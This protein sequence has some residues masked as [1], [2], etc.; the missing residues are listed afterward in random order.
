MVPLLLINAPYPRKLK[1]YGQPTSL[2]YASAKVAEWLD[3]SAGPDAARLIN[4]N[5]VSPSEFE[6]HVKHALPLIL[7]E[8]RPRVVAI[9]LTT[10][11]LPAARRL[12]SVVKENCNA[13]VVFGGP[14]EDDANDPT[15]TWDS[16][17]DLSVAGDGECALNLIVQAALTDLRADAASLVRLLPIKSVEGTA[18]IYYRVQQG[19][20]SPGS[21]GML[22][23][24][25][26][27]RPSVDISNLPLQP[28]RLLDPAEKFHYG[29]FRERSGARKATAQVMTQRGCI[30]RCDF[31]SESQGLLQRSIESVSL[32][33]EHLHKEG[34]RA[35][36]FD[37]STFTNLSVRRVGYLRALAPMLSRLGFECGCQTR[38]DMINA[39]LVKTIVDAGFT[40]VYFGIESF[41]PSLLAA[42]GKHY[43]IDT[44]HN[45][46][47]I[48]REA[49]IRVGAS[50]LLGAPDRN[51]CTME[52]VATATQTFRAIRTYIDDGPVTLVSLNAFQYYP[53]TV[54]TISLSRTDPQVADSR[55]QPTFLFPDH[56]PY[57]LLEENPSVCPSGLASVMQEIL[58]AAAD[59]LGPSLITD[60]AGTP[61][62]NDLRHSSQQG[63]DEVD[64]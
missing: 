23:L 26:P 61:S 31:C 24:F 62:A 18:R 12:A 37:D 34:Y 5:L 40:Y 16:H 7:R 19:S 41:V 14:H 58:F 48:C 25:D 50:L 63:G 33:L 11:S 57:N 13:L 10:A 28:R 2:L 4:Y 47:K 49:G 44:V 29:I 32:E 20:K 15:A 9:S 6:S 56:F 45:A 36:F 42:L 27:A 52:T 43:T 1:F 39:E 22:C 8:L 35:V 53:G 54:S 17:V 3:H 51:H 38:V 59:I 60:G 30:A 64:G 46:L 55:A 21:W